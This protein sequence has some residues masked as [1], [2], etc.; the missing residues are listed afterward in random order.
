MCHSVSKILLSH[1]G[2]TNVL[3]EAAP[4]SG[5]KPGGH[6]PSL[7]SCLHRKEIIED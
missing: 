6:S 5:V 7:K 1:T 4:S 2:W 3:V